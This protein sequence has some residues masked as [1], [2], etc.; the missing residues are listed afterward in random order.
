MKRISFDRMGNPVVEVRNRNGV[1]ER[2]DAHE[3]DS[4]DTAGLCIA[5]G[6]HRPSGIFRRVG[7]NPYQGASVPE[8]KKLRKRSGLDYLRTLSDEIKRRKPDEE[9]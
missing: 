7:S 5:S 2:V 9:K 8:S 3:L 4:L 6:T 1:Y